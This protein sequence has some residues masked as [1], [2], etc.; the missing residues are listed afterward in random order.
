MLAGDA[1]PHVLVKDWSHVE[2]VFGAAVGALQWRS[3]V[4]GVSVDL[5]VGCGRGVQVHV[6]GDMGPP[7]AR[8]GV[9]AFGCDSEGLVAPKPGMGFAVKFVRKGNDV[10]LE[11]S[12]LT[13]S[14]L[15]VCTDAGYV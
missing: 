7:D 2:L 10:A 6:C 12:A 15:D 11:V 1:A 9:E 14:E 8:F 3:V 4:G 13:V 5:R